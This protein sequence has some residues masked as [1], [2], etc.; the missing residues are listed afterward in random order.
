MAMYPIPE[1][2]AHASLMESMLAALAASH[3][4]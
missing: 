2:R 1:Q 4:K 3:T